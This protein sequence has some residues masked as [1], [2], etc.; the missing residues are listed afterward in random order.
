MPKTNSVIFM[1]T[2][3]IAAH[4][5]KALIDNKQIHIKA[6]VCQPDK[7]IGRKKELFLCPTKK[8]AIENNIQVFQPTKIGDIYEHIKIINPDLIYTCAYGQFVPEKI[9]SIPKYGCVNLH[10]SLLPLLR[11]GA[12]IHYSIINDFKETGLT[13]MYM[14][15]KMDAGNIIK[16]FNIKIEAKETYISLYNKLCLFAYDVTINNIH[17]LFNSNVSS[18]VQDEDQA[19]FA[20][21]ITREQEMIDW[22]KDADVIDCF[23][24]GLYNK[25]IASTTYDGIFIKIHEAT[26]VCDDS[27]KMPGT[28]LDVS[29]SGIMIKAKKDAILI[30]VLQMPSKK[31][32][33]VAQ[34][35]NG[36]HN[37]K[38]GKYFN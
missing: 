37:F 12:P 27:K 35:I 3:E 8:V 1:G 30:S 7:P 25:P 33:T 6:V 17:N 18:K 13:L 22:N 34:L 31:P 26:K 32:L 38:I 15:K 29:K 21:N 20:Y 36:N 9:L 2:P 10:A 11:G 16:Q 28:I 14:A 4:C 19:T 23:I 24:R 5:L